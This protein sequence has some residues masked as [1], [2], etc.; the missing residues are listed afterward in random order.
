MMNNDLVILYD[1]YGPL[2]NESA[3]QIFEE[4]YFN[5]LSLAEISQLNQVSRNAIH[6]RLKDIELKLINYEHT[7]QLKSKKDQVLALI[8]NQALKNQIDEIL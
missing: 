1:I 4:Y 3:K 2:L 7:M 8:S 6:K 5:N